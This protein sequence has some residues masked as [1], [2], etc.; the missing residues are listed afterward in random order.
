MRLCCLLLLL[1]SGCAG[2]PSSPSL[3]PA[4][5]A[6]TA[7]EESRGREEI[8]LSATNVPLSGI[9]PAQSKVGRLTY[10]G[11]LRLTSSDRRFGG[12]SGLD[13]GFGPLIAVTDRGDFVEFTPVLDEARH[14]VG[15]RDATITRLTD[16]AGRRLP[17]DAAAQAEGLSYT[18]TGRIA[19]S[20]ANSPRL[21]SYGDIAGGEPAI[22]L[23]SPTDD[24]RPSGTSGLHALAA[25]RVGAP[26]TVPGASDGRLWWCVNTR[27]AA[28]AEGCTGF[29]QRRDFDPALTLSGL[30]LGPLDFGALYGVFRSRAAGAG[31]GAKAVIAEIDIL[32]DDGV[33]AARALAKLSAPLTVAG[34]EGI[35]A[36]EGWEDGV[37]RLYLVSDD[38]FSGSTLLLAFDYRMER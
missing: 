35:V 33:Y 16:E 21:L 27:P 29:G 38:D 20:F 13:G 14:L 32:A 18:R 12:L 9:D 26:F 24:Q 28:A 30:D 7:Q 31:A 34:F 6:T 2:P 17:P 11:G 25:L 8:V 19:V 10:A 5:S 36:L 4:T 23:L 3:A 1:L 15:V 22:A 37:V